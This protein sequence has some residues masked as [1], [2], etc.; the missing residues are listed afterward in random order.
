MSYAEDPQTLGRELFL[1]RN[2]GVSLRQ[3]RRLRAVL[4]PIHY[5]TA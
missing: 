5:G 3:S 4:G 1:T 2:S